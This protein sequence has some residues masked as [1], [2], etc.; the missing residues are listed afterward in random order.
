MKQFKDRSLLV[1]IFFI[2][3]QLRCNNSPTNAEKNDMDTSS[4][5]ASNIDA[6]SLPTYDPNMDAYLRGGKLINK[7]GD[8]LGVKMYELIVKPDRDYSK[9]RALLFTIKP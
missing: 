4:A 7:L 9:E 2:L 5:S 3:F 8:S 1:V 6:V